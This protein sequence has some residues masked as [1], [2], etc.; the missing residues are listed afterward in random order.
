MDHSIIKRLENLEKNVLHQD[1]ALHAQHDVIAQLCSLLPGR[2]CRKLIAALARHAGNLDPA[3]GPERITGY[4]TELLSIAS[5]IG[6]HHSGLPN[7]DSSY[8]HAF[9]R[10]HV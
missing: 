1:G 2:D 10:K 5:E 3:L 8:E 6:R 7:P 4:Q 9:A